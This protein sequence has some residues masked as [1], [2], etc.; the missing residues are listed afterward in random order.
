MPSLE[1][2]KPAPMAA[3]VKHAVD[4]KMLI[5]WLLANRGSA[6]KSSPPIAMPAQ[7]DGVMDWFMLIRPCKCELATSIH[8][9]K[10]DDGHDI[11]GHGAYGFEGV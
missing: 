8:E 10:Y 1:Y 6:K 4:V 7:P 3:K 5:H 11:G 9:Q 2:I